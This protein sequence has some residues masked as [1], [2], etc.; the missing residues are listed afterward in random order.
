M[1]KR[2]SHALQWLLPLAAAIYLIAVLATSDLSA[3]AA[4]LSVE[5]LTVAVT[6]AVV[7]GAT[8]YLLAFAWSMTLLRPGADPVD[9]STA[10][11]AYAVTSFAK[12][13]PGNVF[14]FVGRQLAAKRMG[15]THMA[16]GQASAVE[17]GGH[18]LVVALLTVALLPF[19][20]ADVSWADTLPMPLAYGLPLLVLGL[21]VS[22]AGLYRFSRGKWTLPHLPSWR[23]LSLAALCQ[24]VFFLLYAALGAWM[25][26]VVLDAPL[27]LAPHFALAWLVAW[28]VGFVTP[29][30]P[31]GLGVREACLLLLLAPYGES[32]VILAFAGISR[33][34]LLAGEAVF[35]ASGLLLF[36]KK[37]PARR[38]SELYRL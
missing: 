9:L 12:Y 21:A 23:R 16:A 22:F 11:K 4:R 1:P 6:T 31:G 36:R 18:L 29:G 20:A 2:L 13:L 28:L 5:T 38:M 27:R 17:V 25:A 8:L 30:A 14:H 10:V 37:D 32:S 35:T 24:L 34:S 7:Y 33:L 26:L 15:L 3:A 19:A